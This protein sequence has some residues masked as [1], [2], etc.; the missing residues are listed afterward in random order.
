[1]KENFPKFNKIIKDTS[2]AVLG[3]GLALGVAS[4]LKSQDL[5]TQKEEIKKETSFEGKEDVW[6]NVKVFI[7]NQGEKEIIYVGPLKQAGDQILLFK[8]KGEDNWNYSFNQNIAPGL[9][10]RESV[11]LVKEKTVDGKEVETWKKFVDKGFLEYQYFNILEARNVDAEFEKIQKKFEKKEV[12]TDIEKDSLLQKAKENEKITE[13][14]TK[15]DFVENKKNNIEKTPDAFLVQV[16]RNRK[17]SEIVKIPYEEGVNIGDEILVVHEMD[18]Y[19]DTHSYKKASSDTTSV[20][21][22][23]KNGWGVVEEVRKAKV[24]KF[25]FDEDKNKK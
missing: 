23:P 14:Y 22:F 24:L 10:D 13:E 5:N 16:V 7:P 15:E 6:M 17:N 19:D 9:K 2:K 4:G 25:I 21:N 18:F 11:N 3:V 12:K 1:M 20:S 8:R